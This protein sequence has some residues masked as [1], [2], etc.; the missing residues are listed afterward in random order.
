MRGLLW[1]RLDSEHSNAMRTLE[2]IAYLFRRFEQ[3]SAPR[4]GVKLCSQ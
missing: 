1:I 2:Q 3:M 4:V